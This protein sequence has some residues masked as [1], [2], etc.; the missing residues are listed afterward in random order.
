MQID[1]LVYSVQKLETENEELRRNTSSNL[2]YISNTAHPTTNQGE[3]NRNAEDGNVEGDFIPTFGPSIQ[4]RSQT[5]TSCSEFSLRLL[6]YFKGDGA[7]PSLQHLHHYDSLNI[8]RCVGTVSS[9]TF[10]SPSDAQMLV[11]A[12]LKFMYAPEPIYSISVTTNAKFW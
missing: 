12:V 10:P 5:E 6:R 3:V 8:H 1:Q 9:Q 11:E 2:P 7:P 4:P